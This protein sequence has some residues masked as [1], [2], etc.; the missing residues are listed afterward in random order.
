MSVGSSSD[1]VG[2]G[3]FR[4]ADYG[5]VM[6]LWAEG[7]LPLKPQGR[8]SREAIVR[9]VGLP[10]V[11][12]LVA[13]AGEGARSSARSWPPT[14]AARA[15]STAWRWTPPCGSRGLGA[16]L[17]R[18]GRTL[19]R[20]PRH[21]H[22]GLPHRGRQ[23]RIDGRLRETRVQEASGDHLFR[24]AQVSRRLSASPLFRFFSHSRESLSRRVS[25]RERSARSDHQR[26]PGV[27]RRGGAGKSREK[28]LSQEVSQD[29]DSEHSVPRCN[30][31]GSR[32]AGEQE[33]IPEPKPERG[34]SRNPEKTL[35]FLLYTIELVGIHGDI[36]GERTS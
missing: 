31:T 25:G 12:F 36:Q 26:R 32:G 28:V 20:V 35:Y 4:P 23:C 1:A 6:E 5:R 21:G 29:R 8:D 11:R 14:T 22:P 19:A 17:V 34:T 10:N 9:Q 16:R 27:A 7:G 2:I 24:Q 3:D 33:D 13:E 18:R 30:R 15:G